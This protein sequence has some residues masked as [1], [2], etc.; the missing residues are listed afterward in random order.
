MSE[1]RTNLIYVEAVPGAGKTTIAKALATLLNYRCFEEPVDHV[2]LDRFYT[3]PE[4][5]AFSLQIHLLHKRIGIQMLAA[6]EALYSDTFKGSIVDRSL[7]G[8]ATFAE[9]HHESG[10]ITDLDWE[11]YKTAI[12]N[13]KLMIWPPTILLYLEVEPE[14]ALERVRRRETAG[15]RPYESK[16]SLDYLKRLQD[17]YE[18]MVAGATRGDWP[19]G[20]AVKVL[21]K[22]WNADIPPSKIT[23]CDCRE[24][25]EIREQG[26][27]PIDELAN[28]LKGYN[29]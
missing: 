25:R 7:F 26:L 12:L 6:C 1:E 3:K 8:D 23:G 16:I 28:E 15:G 20:H 4:A 2:R 10:N 14:V 29:P 22:D 11:T 24:C 27:N 13:M 9:M 17:K 5:Y 21:R 19:W 18:S